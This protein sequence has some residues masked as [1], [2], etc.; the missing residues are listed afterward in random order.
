LK[1]KTVIPEHP[2]ARLRRAASRG[3]IALPGVFNALSAKLVERAGFRGCYLSGAALSAS[4]AAR[5]DIGLST[6]SEVV[7]QA[8]YITSAVR[9][10]LLVDG[11]TGFGGFLNIARLVGELESAGCAGVQIEDQRFPKRCGHLPGKELVTLR[12]M[13][14]KIQAARASRRDKNFLIVAR[15]DAR[16][17]EGLSGAVER[18]QVYAQAGAD[19][20][21]PEA[22]RTREEFAVVARRV[23]G[24]LMANMTEFGQTPLI[25]VKDFQKLGYRIVLFPVT[26]LRAAAFAMESVLREIQ[27]RGTQKGALNRLQTR[28]Q[29]YDLID[30]SD[31]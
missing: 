26:T 19:V 29:L 16:S 1:R 4:L 18:A 14:E 11:D 28:R 24:L 17:V 2:G 8:R 7:E 20:I 5:P 31:F 15:T 6:L 21:F 27:R 23:R 22:L 13:R 3:A 12:E 30:Y 10:P 25:P 9:T